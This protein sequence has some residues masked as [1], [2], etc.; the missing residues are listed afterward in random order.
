ML[1]KRIKG[2]REHG[3]QI[4]SCKRS[5]EEMVGFAL[6]IIIVAVVLLIFL[7]FSLRNGKNENVE[8]YEVTSFI[9]SFLHYTTDCADGY[10]PRYR[11]IQ[12]LIIDCNRKETCLDGRETCDVLNSTLREIVEESWKV[13]GD[14]PTKSYSMKINS[15]E[16][17]IL[18][19][20]EGNA[21][22]NYK[23]SVENLGAE[24][25]QIIME[26]YY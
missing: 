14:R 9:Q 10:E 16:V 17:R 6:I 24:D 23:S 1:D 11:T 7:S 21:T 5:Q 19:L 15:K 22:N 25:I 8:D 12:Q 18:E 20:S 3:R 26:V 4:I 2:T 13:E